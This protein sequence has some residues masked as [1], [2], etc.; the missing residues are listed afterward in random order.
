MYYVPDDTKKC[1]YY[2]CERCRDKFLSLAMT[3][4]TDCPSCVS[5]VDME[6]GPGEEMNECQNTAKLIRVLEGE[7]VFKMDTLLSLAVTGGNYD[8]I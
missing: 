8:W 5:E 6:M 1:G 4:K 7:D 2:E 3:D